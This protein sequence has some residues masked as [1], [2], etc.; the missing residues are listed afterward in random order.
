MFIFDLFLF[1]LQMVA[2]GCDEP[3]SFT[4]LVRQTH[5]RK[6]GT[7]IHHRAHSIVIEVEEAVSQMTSDDGSP[8]ATPRILLNQEY[9]KVLLKNSLFYYL[10]H[11][12]V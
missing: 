12:Y 4:D 7:F 11:V 3:P 10:Q 1:L 2:S 9:I 6:D 8:N 5:T